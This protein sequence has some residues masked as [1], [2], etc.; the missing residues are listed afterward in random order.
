[1]GSDTLCLYTN[2]REDIYISIKRGVKAWD[3]TRI[4]LYTKRGEGLYIYKNRV[5]HSYVFIYN[6]CP[7]IANGRINTTTPYHSTIQQIGIMWP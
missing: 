6:C 2:S 7:N 3:V 5:S 1:M 4:C